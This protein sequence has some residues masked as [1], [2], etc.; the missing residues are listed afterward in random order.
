MFLKEQLYQDK[1]VGRND[2][3]AM[4]KEI[5]ID[6]AELRRDMRNMSSEINAKLSMIIDTIIQEKPTPESIPSKV[7]KEKS[8][9]INR[10]SSR[11]RKKSVLNEA[12][13]LAHRLSRALSHANIPTD[14]ENQEEDKEE[15][16]PKYIPRN[17][18]GEDSGI[19]HSIR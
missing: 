5:S 2:L 7:D 19:Q 10:N 15:N 17:K 8:I 6:V 18:N 12:S 11:H 3:D 16:N 1:A 9:I 14:D 13:Y 4:E